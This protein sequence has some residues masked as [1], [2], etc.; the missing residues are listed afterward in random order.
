[1]LQP[2]SQSTQNAPQPKFCWTAAG[3]LIHE[4]KVLLVKHKKLG[5]WLN[6]GGHLEAGELPHHAAEREF[7][8]ETGIKVKALP[9]GI[10]LKTTE[11]SFQPCPFSVDLHWV[12][13][14]NYDRRVSGE[15]PDPVLQKKWPLGCEQHLNFMYLV[16][17][18]SDAVTPTQNVEETLGI[19]WFTKD[20]VA[21]HP[22][23]LLPIR[24]EIM[25]AFL[26]LERGTV[27]P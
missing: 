10:S 13:R 1:M 11:T 20:E 12:C 16:E 19:A 17:P 2:N 23:I 22:D 26:C 27:T 21:N 14:E 18:T 15:S 5:I 9:F 3:V 4:A 24:H 6:P 25:Q 8:E 7:W